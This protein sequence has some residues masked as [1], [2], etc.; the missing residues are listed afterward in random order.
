M[1]PNIITDDFKSERDVSLMYL[2]SD[3]DDVNKMWTFIPSRNERSYR[4][5]EKD[6]MKN[7][8][9]KTRKIKLENM[10]K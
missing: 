9:S 10:N 7:L 3:L 1:S 4:I 8:W 5:S 6:C 2:G